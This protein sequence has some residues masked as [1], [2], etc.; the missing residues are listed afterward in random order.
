MGHTKMKRF[1]SRVMKRPVTARET[2]RRVHVKPLRVIVS[3]ALL[4]VSNL[5]AIADEAYPSRPV[6]LIVPASAGGGFDLFGR[7][8][9]K[10]LSERWRQPLV[11]DNRGGGAGN[12]AASI[13]LNAKPDGYTIFIW[14][15][16]LLI[17]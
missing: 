15:D 16:A 1:L 8:L 10:R 3:I 5:V 17:N 2:I 6:T 7:Q 13:V 11:V 14:N 4:A 9:G 12:I